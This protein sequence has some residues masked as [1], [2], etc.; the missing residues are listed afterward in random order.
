MHLCRSEDNQ[1]AKERQLRTNDHEYNAQFQYV[2]NYI[3]TSKYSLLTFL[4]LN[5]FEQFRRVAN[6][7]F[8][9]QIIIMSI[10][11]I[12]ALSP[13]ATAV[14]L[15]CVLA[16]TGIKDAADDIKRHKSDRAVNNRKANILT[17]NGPKEKNWMDL[18]VGEVL[19]ID[20]NEQIP[21]DIVVLTTSE[22]NGLCYIETAELDG[23]TNLKCRQ[24]LP[25]TGELGDDEQQLSVVQM[26]ITCDPP[27][28]RLEKLNG[29]L[30]YDGNNY[31]LDNDNVI[32]RGC[33][34]RNTKWVYGVVI[35]AGH[36]TK[37]MMNTGVSKF[38]RTG[39]DK[40][41][42]SL[43][44][45]IAAM[46]GII[47]TLCSI[48]TTIWEELYGKDFQ[49]YL[50]WESFYK[51]SVVII[52]IVHWPSFV[53]V[54]NTL[55]P[56]SLYISVEVIRLGQSLWINWDCSMYYEKMDTPAVARTTTLSEE[57]G[58][59]EY[60]FSD[61]T[62]T[63]TQNV[64]TFKKCSINGRLY[65]EPPDRS[66][67][68]KRHPSMH[69]AHNSCQF[70][71][72]FFDCPLHNT[73]RR[74]VE[75][76]S[77]GDP[78]ETL[79]SS[80]SIREEGAPDVDLS[81]NPYPDGKFKFNDQALLDEINLGN[82]ECHE[83]FRLLAVCHTVMVERDN[84][85][86]EY[87]AQSPDEAALVTAARNFG[88]TFL[89]RSPTTL[90]I[91]VLREE[92]IYE[93]LAI[94]DF[95]NERKRMSVIVRR[96]DQIK[97]YCKGADT[98]VYEL[99]DQSCKPLM[100]KTMQ[101]LNVFAAEGL[102]TLV[103][104]YKDIPLDVYKEWEARY[105]EASMAM[106]NRDE[107]VQKAYE[108]IEQNLTLIGATAI[109]DKLQDDVPD[110]IATLA[111]AN[112]KIWVLTGDKVETAINIGYSCHLLTDDMTEVF[113]I[114]GESLESVQKAIAE[115]KNKITGGAGLGAPICRFQSKENSLKDVEVEVISYKDNYLGEKSAAVQALVVHLVKDNLQ[116][117]TLAI[118]DGAND[119]SMIKAAHIGV[120]ISGQEGMQAVMASDFSF[121]QF[122][123][124]Q[125]L[126]LVH[127][128]WSYFRMS[129]FL[130]YFFY[131]NFAFTLCQLWYA[132]YTGF[133][134]QTLYDAWFISFYNVFFTSAPVVFLAVLDQDVSDNGCSKYPLLYIPGQTNLL[135]N[136]KIFFLSL[137]YGA[138]TS[139]AIFFLS[140]GAFRDEIVKDGLETSSVY[141]FGTVVAAIL[142]VVVNI[143]IS[144]LTQYWTWINHFFTWGSIV[145]YFVF[146]FV[147]YAE[148]VFKLFPQGHYYGMQFE[149]YGNPKFWFTL[150]LV[151]AVS[152]APR[153]SYYFVD[154][155]MSATQS[156]IVRRK[157]AHKRMRFT[158]P[159]VEYEPQLVRRRTSKRSSYAFAHQ[160]G[161]G[162][163]VMSPATFL[164]KKLRSTTQPAGQSSVV[165]L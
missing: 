119:V 23:E 112:I 73:S 16:A 31:S 72:C 99:L 76:E 60:I 83:L 121:A 95:N 45:W 2:N 84:G 30:M 154:N 128:R 75:G 120:G 127:G 53:M 90:T 130:N 41:T 64:M 82:K 135:F 36:D 57:L 66:S 132:F 79:V 157:E 48:A 152:T 86:L 108:E 49:V 151:L 20:N 35:Y 102:R 104:A 80:V 47:C 5:L 68:G 69:M 32:L 14:P 11:K 6:L 15:I 98:I 18:Q 21:A 24:P 78:E 155:E 50:P 94:L 3:R 115:C 105:K 134:A 88:F 149:V 59:I 25:E 91:D 143:E 111:E 56:I 28:N 40:L 39:L 126:L 139:L 1:E 55:I 136:K 54:L 34:L 131:K 19:R 110:T 67:S 22:D 141:F 63:L 58:Q 118:G 163:I 46:L 153:L 87:Q 142:V 116:A 85:N 125:R 92:E 147:F 38:K 8:I 113:T 70:H 165:T 122:K 160:E 4:P 144:F 129:K 10:P 37:L 81:K 162:K 89:E 7:Y 164:R 61:K 137:L 97:L 146:Y 107:L 77:A 159:Q 123:Y 12:T 96:N 158:S 124:L 106:E 13:E 51:D 148:F 27:N 71:S 17:D 43:I 140:Y 133:S 9:L 138:L 44:L 156:D 74:H 114:D 161:F 26:E 103:T 62:G 150:F 65:G 33:V 93:L 101:H 117:V 42:N 145:F 29:R 52:G 100:T 109:E